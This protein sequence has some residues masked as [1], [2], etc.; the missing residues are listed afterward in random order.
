MTAARRA[1]IA[2]T[3]ILLLGW[4]NAACAATYTV[5]F[6]NQTNFTRY[7]YITPMNFFTLLVSQSQASVFSGTQRVAIC[8]QR[9]FSAS[10][11]V[12]VVVNG[13]RVV[14]IDF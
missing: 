14:N 11:C 3:A 9:R 12:S 7:V 5:L 1:I 6:S 10:V 8:T 13:S 4:S 2:A